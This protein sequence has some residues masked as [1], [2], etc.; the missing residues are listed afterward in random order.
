ME[1]RL[2]IYTKTVAGGYDSIPKTFKND[3]IISINIDKR[4]FEVGTCNVLLDNTA[5]DKKIHDIINTSGLGYTDNHNMI[6]LYINDEIAFTGVIKEYKFDENNNTYCFS[7][8]DMIYKIFKTIDCTPYLTY[9]NTT[10]KQIIKSIFNHAGIYEV[11]FADDISDYYVKSIKIEYSNVYIDILD[12]FFNTMYARFSCNNDG[13]VDIVKAYPPYNGAPSIKYKLESKDFISSGQYDR[14]DND[15]RNK[16]IVKASD[17]DVQ[18][19]ECPYLVKHCNGEIFLDVIDEEMANTLE[20]KRNVALKYFRDKI[21]HSKKFSFTTV[22]GNLN[23]KIGDI[24]RIVFNKSEGVKGWGMVNGISS[25]IQ[26]GNWQDTL[27]IELLVSN[28]WINPKEV[29]GNYITK[30]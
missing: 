4:I 6:K 26:D 22:N 10:A 18:A 14:S 11:N 19:F 20:K 9:K 29:S 3:E 1:V 28:S 7:A 23:R 16:V 12:K 8:D 15:I 21:R 27:E 5:R 30:S 13:S 2:E 24:A 25:N 17:I